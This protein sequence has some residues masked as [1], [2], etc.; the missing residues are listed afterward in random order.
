MLKKKI[1]Q[2]FLLYR[3][4]IFQRFRKSHL[5]HRAIICASPVQARVPKCTLCTFFG[6]LFVSSFA[7]VPLLQGFE[8]D[9]CPLEQKKRMWVPNP[10]IKNFFIAG[11]CDQIFFY[12]RCGT[13]SREKIFF[14]DAGPSREMW[15]GEGAQKLSELRTK[16][17]FSRSLLKGFD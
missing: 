7:Y 13:N 6:K 16:I 14:A 9:K 2:I 3:S 11:I 8:R 15:V 17:K 4:E 1:S 12:R 10:R 5:E